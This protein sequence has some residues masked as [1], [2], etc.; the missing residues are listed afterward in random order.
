MKFTIEQDLTAKEAELILKCASLDTRLQK[1]ANYIRQYTFSI[2]ASKGEKIYQLPI[3]NI[4]YAESVDSK[5]FLYTKEDSYEISESLTSLEQMLKG[6]PIIRI[7]KSALLNISFLKCVSPY[8]N[9]RLN[10]ELSNG[11]HLIISRNYIPEVKKALQASL[12]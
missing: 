3:E 4:Y 5:T 9:H 11:E 10:A 2:E 8:P 7:S 12:S 1:L 6:T